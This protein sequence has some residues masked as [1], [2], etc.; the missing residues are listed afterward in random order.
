MKVDITPENHLPLPSRA[1]DFPEKQENVILG[2]DYFH[3][4][5]YLEKKRI[6]R[7]GS[8]FLLMLL[9]IR[10][11]YT[12]VH[13]GE[14][15]MMLDYILS[16]VTRETD[17]KGWYE[18]NVTLGIIFTE[19]GSAGL[20]NA[21]A[22][23]E[24]NISQHLSKVLRVE[25]LEQVTVRFEA[26][27]GQNAKKDMPV[28]PL[29]IETP[30]CEE[31][32]QHPVDSLSQ[33]VKGLPGQL[34][35]ITTVDLF[36]I[37]SACALSTWARFQFSEGYFGSYPQAFCIAMTLYITM[38]YIFDLYNVHRSARPYEIVSRSAI[39]TM[40]AGGLAMA[41]FYLVPQWK[42]G[43][44][45]LAIQIPLV[46]ALFVSWR[47][48]HRKFFRAAQSKIGALVLGNG[49]AG[50]RA[51]SL[52]NAPYSPF[53]AK[54]VITETPCI[55]SPNDGG[56]GIV[57]SLDNI[58]EIAARLGV[59]AIVMSQPCN[60]S[61]QTT[62]KILE[63]RLKGV[64]VL[65]MPTLFE[66]LA[67]RIPVQ[68]IQDQWLLL[69]DGFSLLSSSYIQRIKRVLDFVVALILAGASL[70]VVAITALAIRLESRGPILYRQDRVGKGGKV[71]SVMK[72]R[73][74]RCDAEAHGARWAQKRDP[75]VTR[76]GR[77][78]RMFRIDE[79][80]QIWNVLKGEMSIVGPR[81]ERPEFVKQLEAKIPYFG[82][83]HT[84]R[85][86]ITGWAQVKYPYGASLEDAQRKL[87]YDLYYVKNMSILLDLKILLKTVGVVI[88][89]EGAR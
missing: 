67:D 16:S 12:G 56:P 62:R 83:R 81:P 61:S 23:I 44:G 28:G 86:G 39:A 5:L 30:A 65:D 55:C 84:V 7:S 59:R 52:L 54:G 24:R 71:F 43:R 76:V 45:I 73:S 63:A 20:D 34:W 27:S 32:A 88:L 38:F 18:S 75:R 8:V 41:L 46:W 47:M 13:P 26:Y 37:A 22:S 4:M 78:I 69:A 3:Q 42:F 2:E 49:D 51:I 89:G 72:F 66:R 1:L 53:E 79:L 48:L 25:Q 58:S 87:E 29:D 21:K 17:I 14:V 6:Q 70:P 36:L 77:I 85:P 80:P 74:M 35:F 31:P 15:P 64:E 11:F 9:D 57:G 19:L 60:G 33:A 10:G 68:H 50:N 40:L 82:V